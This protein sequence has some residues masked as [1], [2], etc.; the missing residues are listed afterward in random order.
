MINKISKGVIATSPPPHKFSPELPFIGTLRKK[1]LAPTLYETVQTV[2][3]KNV[4]TTLNIL[5]YNYIRIIRLST[6]NF[7]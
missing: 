1:V 5:L 3:H 2:L 6:Y 4:V 7:L